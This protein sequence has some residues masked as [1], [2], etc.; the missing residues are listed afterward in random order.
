MEFDTY[1]GQ[2]R[3]GNGRAIKLSSNGILTFPKLTAVVL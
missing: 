1:F 2:T 3:L